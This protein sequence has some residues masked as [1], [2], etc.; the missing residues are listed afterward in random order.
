MSRI[1]TAKKSIQR[2]TTVVKSLQGANVL[3]LSRILTTNLSL[4][5]NCPPIAFEVF[6]TDCTHWTIGS[7]DFRNP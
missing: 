3:L 7:L 2:K 1:C 6:E 5:N 4:R